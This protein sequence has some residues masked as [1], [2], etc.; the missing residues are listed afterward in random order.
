MSQISCTIRD[1]NPVIFPLSW[2]MSE[3][4][5]E[6]ERETEELREYFARTITF[7]ER[8]SK[9]IEELQQVKEESSGNNWDGYGA[10]AIDEQAYQNAI[11][12]IL[13]LPSGIP[14]PEIS[15]D[16]DG[17]ISFEWY[18]DRRQLF[19]VSIGSRKQLAYAGL[20]GLNKT[21]GVELFYDDMP[22]I[23]LDNI[24]RLYPRGT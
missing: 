7:G 11:L 16:P 15:V 17:E 9:M 20:Y 3:S 22:N 2:G 24:S 19:S 18:K 6:L 21:W 5:R 23:I 10:R 1:T 12:F 14:K 4:A 8:L 13:S